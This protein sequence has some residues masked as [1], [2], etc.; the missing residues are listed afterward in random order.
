MQI[1]NGKHVMCAAMFTLALAGPALSQTPL[2]PIDE[3]ISLSGPRFGLT[4]LSDGVVQKL[5]VDT[6]ITVAPMVSQFGWQFEKQWATGDHAPTVVTEWVMLFGGLDQG[7]VLPSLS[8]L[9]GMRTHEGTEFGVGPNVTPLG[10]GLVIAA[11]TTMR[12]GPLNI[13][14]NVAFVPS[15]AGTRVS[16][17]TGFNRRKR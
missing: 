14:F 9:V 2:P 8:W 11:G 7:I 1:L 3:P 15:K 6:D 10:V 17:L 16:M 4:V 12:L 5:K 13:P